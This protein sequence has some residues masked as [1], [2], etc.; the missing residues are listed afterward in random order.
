MRLFRLAA[1]VSAS[2]ALAANSALAVNINWPAGLSV[3]TIPTLMGGYN[4]NYVFA[5]IV[6]PTAIYVLNGGGFAFDVYLFDDIFEDWIPSEPIFFAGQ[7]YWVDSPVAQSFNP[8]LRVL[9][10]GYAQGPPPLAANRY[11]FQGAPTGLP[12]NYQ[13]IFGAPPNDETAL[14]RFIPGSTSF[15]RNATNYRYYYY[16]DGVWTPDAPVLDS[17]EP[18]LIIYPYLSIKYTVGGN[19]LTITMTWPVRGKLEEAEFP[20]GPWSEVTTAGNTYSVT[21]NPGQDTG[22]FYRVRED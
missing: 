3:G 22:K 21:P 12:A 7:G 4:G 16:K 6:G 9:G 8:T 13:D 11:F 17:L 20:T 19:P 10:G 5:G 2:L 14:L 1:V 15:A 18:A